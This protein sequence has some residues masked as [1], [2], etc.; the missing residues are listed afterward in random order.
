MG[1]YGDTKSLIYAVL[2]TVLIGRSAWADHWH[3]DHDHWQKHAK[4]HGDGDEDKDVDHDARGCFFQ[5]HDVR[6]ITEYYAPAPRHLPPG[7]AK[8]Y[9][10]T[11]QLPPGWQ[12]K[13]RPLPVA[14]ERQ[15]V[16]LPP[17]Y[18]RGVV[19]GYAVVYNPRTQ[20]IIDV[21]AVFGR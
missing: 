11:G 16:V 19:D 10:R 12:K 8:K 20:V 4:H 7:L 6:V 13:L 14:V 18:R 1:Q 3:D 5:P 17:E 15:L 2:A 9:D 21:V